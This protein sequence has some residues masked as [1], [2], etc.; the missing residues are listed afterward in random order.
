MN[1]QPDFGSGVHP[2][3]AD[4]SSTPN[5]VLNDLIIDRFRL[6]K[7]LEPPQEKIKRKRCA[8]HDVRLS[9]PAFGL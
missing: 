6:G 4:K 5:A 9:D 3:S 2:T 7:D 8:N 1:P